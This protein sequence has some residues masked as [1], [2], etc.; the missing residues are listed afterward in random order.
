MAL[1]MAENPRE[2]GKLYFSTGLRSKK[3]GTYISAGRLE[4]GLSDSRV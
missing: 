3:E 4:L 2:E 1:R